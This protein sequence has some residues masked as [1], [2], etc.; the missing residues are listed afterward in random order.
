[1][2]ERIDIFHHVSVRRVAFGL[3]ENPDTFILAEKPMVLIRTGVRLRLFSADQPAYT[4]LG[5]VVV[6]SARVVETKEAEF[7]IRRVGKVGDSLRGEYHLLVADRKFTAT[8]WSPK[9]VATRLAAA[10]SA[11]ARGRK[12]LTRTL[13]PTP[14]MSP[15]PA[16]SSPPAYEASLA[17]SS[18]NEGGISTARSSSDSGEVRCEEASSSVEGWKPCRDVEESM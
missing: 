6:E 12:P 8:G 7:T 9:H 14:P 1:M 13:P 17:S 18:L 5:W 2:P 15:S 3:G 10:L 11:L 4:H 16:P